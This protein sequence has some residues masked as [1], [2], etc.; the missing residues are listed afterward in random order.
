MSKKWFI[1]LQLQKIFF[2][3]ECDCPAIVSCPSVYTG[4]FPVF[5]FFFFSIYAQMLSMKVNKSSIMAARAP[6]HIS[7]QI[8]LSMPLWLSL[9]ITRTLNLTMAV[10]V[11]HSKCCVFLLACMTKIWLK[12]IGNTNLANIITRWS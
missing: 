1:I 9:C 11:L 3:W 2:N 8:T 6:V 10:W 5:K 12:T 7:M 4:L